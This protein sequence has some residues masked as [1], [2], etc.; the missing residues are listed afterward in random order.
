VAAAP[1]SGGAAQDV[2]RTSTEPPDRDHDGLSDH[3]ELGATAVRQPTLAPLTTALARRTT[4]PVRLLFLGSST[5]YGVGASSPSSR[6]VDQVVSTL[7]RVF[8]S[9]ADDNGPVRDLQR[10]TDRPDS[11][12]GVQGINGGVG[13]STAATYFTDS[14][15][16]GVG[17][18]QPSCVVHMI[19]SND[20]VARVPVPAFRDHVAAVI[21]RID[22]ASD[23]P[24]CHLLLQPVRRVG[25]D[26]E[27]WR[28]YGA[29][30]Q[31]VAQARPRVTFVDVG[32]EFEAHDALGADPDQLIGPDDVHLTDAGHA[33]LAATLLRSLGLTRR[34]L[35]T[36]TDPRRVDTDR[37]GIP[38]K[39]ELRSHV[40]LLRLVP[41][42][43][44]VI[45]RLRTR[46][47]P[48]ESDTD[49]DG[50]SD[51]RELLGYRLADGRVVRS[52]PASSDSD[53]DDAD[54]GREW[55]SPHGDPV[56]CRGRRP[57][58]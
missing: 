49:G 16:Y 21:R 17:V 55:L 38:D 35:G 26:R 34:G 47:L 13:G 19:G 42:T 41:C 51:R 31:Q 36:G 43:G 4:R 20:A 1:A 48:Y 54:D 15:E 37:D 33:L 30:L 58:G 8:P 52:D 44:P 12:P 18:V 40:V 53:G 9:V 6:Y 14:H 57:T 46:T 2:A 7:Q 29:A 23:R 24:P 22:A 10:S 5:T 25:V 27:T 3:A 28:T 32:A 56:T 39:R 45:H 11:T 50:I